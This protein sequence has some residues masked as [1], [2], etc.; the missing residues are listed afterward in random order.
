[1][2]SVLRH[3]IMGAVEEEAMY[4]SV[5]LERTPDL[6]P[7]T[8]SQDGEHQKLRPYLLLADKCFQLAGRD[9]VPL[10]EDGFEGPRALELVVDTASARHGCQRPL[11]LARRPLPPAAP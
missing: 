5:A 9:F 8:G 7:G 11:I 6:I 1:M 4:T 10:E 2:V 3:W